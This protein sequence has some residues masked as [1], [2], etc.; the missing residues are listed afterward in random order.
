MP[1]PEPAA[2]P[3]FAVEARDVS[4]RYGADKAHTTAL[5][6]VSLS[7]RAGEFV[8]LVGPSGCGKSTLLNAIAGLLPSG[9]TVSGSVSVERG[10]GIAYLFQKETLLPW[11]RVL[12]N[13]ELPLELRRVPAAARRARAR[14]LIEQYG[15]GGF[16]QHYPAQLS[17]GMRQRVLLMR[18]LIYEPRIVFLDEPLGSLDAQTRIS[19]QDELRRLW[20]AHGQ[21]FILVTHDL[22]EAIALSNRIVVLGGRPGTLRSEYDVSLPHDLPVLALRR[23]PGFRALEDEIWNDLAEEP[24]EKS[25]LA[26]A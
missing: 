4:V 3:G 12:G 10:G 16:E 24:G 14:R 21:T 5:R 8:S 7:V 11:R 13:V 25:P 20:R 1:K 6:N 15:L 19:L 2:V 17:G 26:L 23:L 9:A 18:T 22:S